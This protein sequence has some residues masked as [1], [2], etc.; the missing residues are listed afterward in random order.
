MAGFEFRFSGPLAKQYGT[1]EAVILY[2]F[3]FWIKHNT[4]NQRNIRDGRV[5]T[6]NSQRA[7]SEIFDFLNERQ[8]RHAL[9]K[10][11]EAGAIIKGNYNAK[12]MDRTCWYTVSDEVMEFYGIAPPPAGME[13]EVMDSTSD[14]VKCN[15]QIC[16]MD[17]TILSDAID[18]YDQP[19][20]DKKPDKNTDN[21]L[22]D[23][24]SDG[25]RVNQDAQF[26]QFWA[27][28]PRKEGKKRARE[29]WHSVMSDS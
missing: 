3:A 13:S 15:R 1:N 23:H 22:S 21:N 25:E 19:I 8:I 4:A 5:W 18:K 16:Q 24:G 10:L 6:Y 2:N 26:A 20:P 11:E 29:K 17:T 14:L 12:K 7:L 27:R 9:K 28:Y